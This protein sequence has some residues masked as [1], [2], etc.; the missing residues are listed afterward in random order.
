MPEAG[1]RSIPLNF[2]C[3][4]AM[5]KEVDMLSNL[6]MMQDAE[7]MRILQG[8][9]C[10]PQSLML[11]LTH[12]S[13]ASLAPTAALSSTDVKPNNVPGNSFSYYSEQHGPH[14]H[15]WSSVTVWSN[16]NEISPTV[17]HHSGPGAAVMVLM[18]LVG[19]YLAVGATFW[20]TYSTTR[21]ADQIRGYSLLSLLAWAL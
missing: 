7:R 11:G 16:T 18:A 13:S 1:I 3:L 5:E 17:Q 20:A 19:L 6:R 14:V 21:C 9:S 4:Q 8:T 2:L 10:Q 12:S 15:S